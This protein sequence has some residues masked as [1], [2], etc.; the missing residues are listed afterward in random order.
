MA[1]SNRI[2]SNASALRIA[3][4]AIDCIGILPSETTTDNA[5]NWVQYLPNGYS[6]LGFGV[7]T[8]SR[9]GIEPG[10]QRRKGRLVNLTAGGGFNIDL[11]QNNLQALMKGALVT[12]IEENS[13]NTPTGVTTGPDE[14]TLTAAAVSATV[15]GGGTSGYVVGDVL[16]T[17]GGT[18]TAATF[19]VS[20]VSSGVVTA[21]TLTTAGSYTVV[22]TDPVTVSGGSGSGTVT[23]NVTWDTE[24]DYYVNDL[25]FAEGF[26]TAANNGLK[27]VDTGP[28]E[29]TV[30]V[31]TT[32]AAETP[33]A[34]AKLWRV[35]HQFDT[36]EV[37]IVV[38][39]A[40]PTLTRNGG[41]SKDFTELGI[42]P[43][44]WVFLGGD[45]ATTRFTNV[46]ASGNLVNTGWCRVRA[47]TATTMSF[48]LTEYTMTAETGTA[49]TVQ[50]FLGG[51]VMHNQAL[52]ANQQ[53]H[54]YQIERE[55][56]EDA[57]GA[58]AEY[59]VGEA[60]NTVACNFPL[61]DKVN[62]DFAFQ[63]LNHATRSGSETLR[64]AESSATR[65]GLLNEEPFN[66][67]GDISYRMAVYT[68]GTTAPTPLFAYVDALTLNIN[69][70]ISRVEVLGA[71]GAVDLS[72]GGLDVSA[73][74]TAI[75][76][77]TASLDT[78]R[79]V[80]DVTINWRLVK[81]NAGVH[82]DLP[83]LTLQSP[84]P[85]VA[86]D[87]AIK[88][89]V[90]SEGNTGASINSTALDH[91]LMITYFPYLPTLAS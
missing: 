50:L 78:I 67:A 15:A 28:D 38:T 90:T 9:R 60:I 6:D 61:K 5:G 2:D 34:T 23:L 72:Y 80:D 56:G 30:P 76:E 57:N 88:L 75:F 82:F 19:T 87:T 47:V 39:G 49:L 24:D 71:D 83:L 65:T 74:I 64:S 32:L 12:D 33:P 45:S 21:V 13:K 79:N 84:G 29:N 31:T 3:E 4:E 70:N 46:D 85:D 10:R 66:T 11:T 41:G 20:A 27:L 8:V 55:L 7:E 68:E 81:E 86:P 77:D 54:T 35:G 62:F 18:G 44:E 63:G 14:Y 43:G 16:T 1:V 17:T 26:T 59:F 89:P 51:Q 53:R 48:D 36:A 25:V 91:T 37:D 22:P 69:N 58:Q 42:Q 40:L 73:E 52:L